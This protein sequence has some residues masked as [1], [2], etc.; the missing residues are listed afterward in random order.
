MHNPYKDYSNVNP[1]KED[2]HRE[3]ET[4]VLQALIYAHLSGLEYA[5]TLFVLHKTWGWNKKEGDIP[6]VQFEDATGMDRSY[7]V[8]SLKNLEK[9]HILIVK[10]GG[11]RGRLS[12]YMLNKY[13]D[14]WVTPHPMETVTIS[15]PLEVPVNSDHE[16]P[17][18]DGETVPPSHPLASNSDHKSPFTNSDH[19]SPIKAGN[20]DKIE[21]KGD[22]PRLGKGDKYTPSIDNIDTLNR[23]KSII[24]TPS[25]EALELA[26]FLKGLILRNNA[27][28]KTP[29]DLTKWAA[30]I[31]RMRKID[32]RTPEEI[33]SVL[34]FSQNDSFW[35]ANILSAGKLREKFDQLYLK[36]KEK[37]KK[38]ASYGAGQQP[39]GRGAGAHRQGAGEGDKFSG[40]HA[41]E[42]GPGEP[43]GGDED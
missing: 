23:K 29:N 14:T 26:K 7:V 20:S 4:T 10:H 43:D 19:K 13:W 5:L 21:G 25:S 32:H 3:I 22:K 38:G 36:A 18:I 1:Q 35:C 12:T 34:E 39:P 17:F 27:K 28:A 8:R 9:K 42:S 40:F 41:I 6:L 15:H 30:E 11:G 31:D 33:R 37:E 16:S 24:N 2:G